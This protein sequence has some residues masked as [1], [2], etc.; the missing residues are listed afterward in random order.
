MYELQKKI[1]ACT[2]AEDQ[3]AVASQ[4]FNTFKYNPHNDVA[5]NIAKIMLA[6]VA[7]GD[8]KT[9][10]FLSKEFTAPTDQLSVCDYLSHASRIIIDYENL[11]QSNK[12]EFL[13][14]FT[15]PEVVKELICRSAT[16]AVVREKNGKISELKGFLLG[17]SG[18]LPGFIKKNKDFGVNIAMGGQNEKNA[19]GHTISNNG[20]SGH[21]YFHHN[22][23]DN[24]LMV[25]LEQ[26]LPPTLLSFLGSATSAA[27]DVQRDTDQ[28]GQ[29]HS[30]TGASDTF[31][32]ALSLYFSDS[33]YLAKLLAE[34]NCLP[35]D[36]YGAMLVELTDENWQQIKDYLQALTSEIKNE[37]LKVNKSEDNTI[38]ESKK[39][40]L[41]CRLLARPKTANSQE[42][43]VVS[44]IALDFA[45]YLQRIEKIFIHGAGITLNLEDLSPR[46]LTTIAALRNGSDCWGEFNSLIEAI[47]QK[48]ASSAQSDRLEPY[49]KAIERLRQLFALQK[50][51]KNDPELHKEQQKLLL[52]SQYDNLQ[53]E[54]TQLIEALS[55]VECYFNTE[56][57]NADASIDEFKATLANQLRALKEKAFSY[58]EPDPCAEEQS[59]D[60]SWIMISTQE[61]A[62]ITPDRVDDLREANETAQ[63]L[64]NRVPK[65]YSQ[66]AMQKA[67]NYIKS[68]VISQQILID[69]N[70]ELN[71]E[72]QRLKK[73]LTKM[74]QGNKELG[75]EHRK[76]TKLN[77]ELIMEKYAQERQ[78]NLYALQAERTKKISVVFP[79]L[80][81]LEN[82][83][84]KAH[85]SEAE[86]LNDLI[87]GI[88]KEIND[89][90]NSPLGEENS[91]LNAF[92]A[93]SINHVKKAQGKLK[94][95]EGLALVIYNLMMAI[96]T[97]GTGFLV[98]KCV[99][100]HYFFGQTSCGTKV[101][102]L[103]ADLNSI[104]P[105]CLVTS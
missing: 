85:F 43:Q 83:L 74:K 26:T 2:I 58:V 20:Y 37:K 65:L 60:A 12:E 23:A 96:L 34:K 76:M 15:A 54:A 10:A 50:Q 32:A 16:H 93:S 62:E 57:I 91:L 77:E 51:Y 86:A 95:K 28:F 103:G 71:T 30:I 61:G 18:L 14:Y 72:N 105:Q 47:L 6:T 52:Q 78:L 84:Q 90:L 55:L 49:K 70:A 25:G 3:Q 67:E 64:L 59:M 9:R 42:Q 92:K 13:T 5:V 19:R 21:I 36:K 31:T 100:G 75:T 97:C 63:N 41:M 22:E 104:T 69:K 39:S 68:N 66:E 7:A 33:L 73:E 24:L 82:K 79:H 44:Y 45:S 87:H 89:Y 53:V 17:V 88:N 27:N 101:K 46:L 1:V 8:F 4:W 56:Y 99:T 98:N 11:S 40:P 81:N 38:E 102:K 48:I 94:D 29:G 35:P 80:R